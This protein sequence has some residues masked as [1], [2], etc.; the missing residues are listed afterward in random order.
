MRQNAAAF[1]PPPSHLGAD[2]VAALAGLQVHDLPHVGVVGDVIEEVLT[3][4]EVAAS[5]KSGAVHALP[6]ALEL[7]SA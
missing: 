6:V 2:L 1:P 7:N 5:E 3:P 4:I